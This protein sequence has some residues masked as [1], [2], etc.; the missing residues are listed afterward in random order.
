MDPTCHCGLRPLASSSGR[1]AVFCGL[2]PSLWPFA[3]AG[4]Q[5]NPHMSA[6]W[7][8]HHV[9]VGSYTVAGLSC[10]GGEGRDSGHA[11]HWAPEHSAGAQRVTASNGPAPCC[12][13]ETQREAS[14]RPHLFAWTGLRAGVCTEDMEPSPACPMGPWVRGV[15]GHGR[16]ADSWE[17][18][19]P[20]G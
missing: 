19:A 3:M 14:V 1:E 10:E 11:C 15:W 13:R 9:P 2:N 12:L 16:P 7:H 20:G 6:L 5:A 4:C 18:G 17:L 8:C